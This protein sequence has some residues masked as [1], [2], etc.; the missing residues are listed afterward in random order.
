MPSLNS[1]FYGFIQLLASLPQPNL[2]TF[3]PRLDA[4]VTPLKKMTFT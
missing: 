1:E 3:L 4:L 2:P